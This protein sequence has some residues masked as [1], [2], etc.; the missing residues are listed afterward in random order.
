[1]QREGQAQISSFAIFQQNVQ[2]GLWPSGTWCG[3]A[4]TSN[5]MGADGPTL[6]EAFDVTYTACLTNM[7]VMALFTRHSFSTLLLLML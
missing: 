4:E 6:F 1:M 5:N 7:V 2:F 3:I